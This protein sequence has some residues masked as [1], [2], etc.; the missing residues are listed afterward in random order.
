VRI[1]ATCVG[2]VGSVAIAFSASGD[3]EILSP[4]ERSISATACVFAPP[5]YPNWC[6]SDSKSSTSIAPWTNSISYGNSAAG[7]IGYGASIAQAFQQSSASSS[8]IQVAIQSESN[9][10][11]EGECSASANAASSF[12]VKFYAI[13]L[14]RAVLSGQA[15]QALN[16]QPQI[17]LSKADG[18]VLY[19][20]AGEFEATFDLEPGVYVYSAKAETSAACSGAASQIQATN[21]VS[22]VNLQPL[23]CP[24]DFNGDSLVDDADF[25]AF[26]SAY[27]DLLCPEA[28]AECPA[29]LN[30]DGLVED[31]D[32]IF[33]AAAY[34][35]LLCP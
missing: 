22:Q 29:D 7:G 2:I 1:S 12:L 33:F 16:V 35:E 32:F 30:H 11:S 15:T 21:W 27:N 5:T 17:T 28:P 25:V 26:V 18:T 6:E 3:V 10:S 19:T 34:N 13:T 20:Y 4:I 24:S 8:S 31:S 9:V 14:T 23:T